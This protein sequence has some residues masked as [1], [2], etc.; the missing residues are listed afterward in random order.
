MEEIYLLKT[1]HNG[2]EISILSQA[3]KHTP[4]L[5]HTFVAGNIIP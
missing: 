1:P 2:N 4:V 5:I 3:E